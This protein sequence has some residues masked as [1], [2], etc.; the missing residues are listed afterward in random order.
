[1]HFKTTF[2]KCKSGSI[3]DVQ[4]RL[5]IIL[6]ISWEDTSVF[7]E[8]IKKEVKF[9]TSFYKYSNYFHIYVAALYFLEAVTLLLLLHATFAVISEGM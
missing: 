6:H 3:S 4:S 2:Q 7:R 1:M 5:H 8:S 9:V